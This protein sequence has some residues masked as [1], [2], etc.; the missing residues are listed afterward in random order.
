MLQCHLFDLP[1]GSD[2]AKSD[3]AAEVSLDATVKNTLIIDLNVLLFDLFKTFLQDC[4][5]LLSN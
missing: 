5:R 1:I 3:L 2:Q 4:I